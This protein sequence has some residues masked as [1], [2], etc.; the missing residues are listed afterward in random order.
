NLGGGNGLHARNR[1]N[2]V[3]QV[4]SE[5]DLACIVVTIQRGINRK[6]QQ[7]FRTEAGIQRPQIEETAGKQSSAYDQQQR[8]RNL[9]D[10][11]R[12]ARAIVGGAAGNAGGFRLQRGS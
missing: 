2:V 5:G 7:V 8:N 10:D 6:L 11:Q 12:F 1:G 3:A 4:L 9:G